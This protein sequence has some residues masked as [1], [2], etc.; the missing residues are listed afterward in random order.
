MNMEDDLPLDPFYQFPRDQIYRLGNEFGQKSGRSNFLPEIKHCIDPHNKK[1]IIIGY[2]LYDSKQIE[3]FFAIH[4]SDQSYCFISESNPLIVCMHQ[5]NFKK[6]AWTE[7][8]DLTSTIFALIHRNKNENQSKWGIPLFNALETLYKKIELGIQALVS[9]DI[10]EEKIQ[11]SD[12]YLLTKDTAKILP[13][14]NSI[15]NLIKD[16]YGVSFFHLS[17]HNQNEQFKDEVDEL[18]KQLQ[19]SG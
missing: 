2:K 13:K 10:P 6:L 17:Q 1:K 12:I 11:Q 5:D 7:R 8:A 18:L 16:G 19:P 15:S 3:K 4:D 9:K 14:M